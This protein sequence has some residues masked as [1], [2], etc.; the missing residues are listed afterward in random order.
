M[1]CESTAKNQSIAIDASVLKRY[2]SWKDLYRNEHNEVTSNASHV[3]HYNYNL[4][5][6]LAEYVAQYELAMLK[7]PKESQ[8]DLVTEMS[9]LVLKIYCGER[10]REQKQPYQKCNK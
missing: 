2:Y 4:L 9:M 8:I 6:L 5:S 10:C 1:R 7:A 3:C